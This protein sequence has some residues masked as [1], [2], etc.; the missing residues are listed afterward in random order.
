M[1]KWIATLLPLGI[2][3]FVV[4]IIFREGLPDDDGEWIAILAM[5]AFSAV[6]L[7]SIHFPKTSTKAGNDESILALW[8]RVKKSELRKR[9]D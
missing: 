6:N 2:L 8:L 7:W 5:I 4:V 3:G 9:L 1:L